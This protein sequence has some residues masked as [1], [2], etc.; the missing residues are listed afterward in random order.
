MSSVECAKLDALD[1]GDIDYNTDGINTQVTYTCNTGYTLDGYTDIICL[2]NGSWQYN[3]SRC[4]KCSNLSSPGNGNYSLYTV[5]S[6]TVTKAAYTC[7]KGYTLMGY[8]E[9]TCQQNGEW[10]RDSPICVKC[11]DR[12]P[13]SSGNF[14]LTTN[15]LQT[16]G[17]Y[18]CNE[19]YILNGTSNVAC[20]ITGDWSY[21]QPT[22]ECV[23][24]EAPQNGSITV[25]QPS[26][27]YACDT[28]Y[29]L[30][31]NSTGMCNTDGTGWSSDT[32]SCVEC[33]SV[34]MVSN[35]NITY[36]SNGVNTYI[37]ILCEEGTTISGNT[38]I[39]CTENGTWNSPLPECVTC[40]SLQEVTVSSGSVT[41]VTNGTVTTANYS[42]PTGYRVKGSQ[43]IQCLSDGTWSDLPSECVCDEPE[44]TEGSGYV[45]SDNGL[46]ITFTCDKGY[47]IN[48][49]VTAECNTD[50][51]GWNMEY[52]N[53][54]KCDNV[55]VPQNGSVSLVSNGTHTTVEFY[56]G[57]GHTLS[58]F[59]V[60]ECQA[61]G[62]WSSTVTTQSCV[63]CESLP[64]VSVVNG[65]VFLSTNGT[66][67][68]AAY[69]CPDGYKV[70]GEDTLTCNNT[71]QW[72]STPSDCV[73]ETPSLLIG[74]NITVVD[75]GYGVIFTCDKGYTM[76]GYQEITCA[77]DGTGWSSS[78]PLCLEC[79]EI[80]T[81]DGGN[82]T[83]VTNGT[84]SAAIYKC[85]V[86]TTLD[87]NT[88]AECQL[89][90][91]WNITAP[92]CVSCP[93]LPNITIETGYVNISTDGM[94]TTAY[95][96]CPPGYIVT[97]EENIT[98]NADG[99]WSSE[100]SDCVCE[101]PLIPQHG[102]YS[103]SINRLSIQYRCDRG[104]IMIG[105][106]TAICNIDGTG[107][108]E[109]SPTCLKCEDLSPPL[110]G[111][112]S[113]ITNGTHSEAVYTCDVGLTLD[114]D[115]TRM[116]LENTT[117]TGGSSQCVECEGI[118][119]IDSG[120]YNK[121]TNGTT[122]SVEYYC[123]PG[124]FIDGS[125]I[126]TCLSD[127]SWDF[128]LPNCY[129]SPPDVILNGSIIYNKTTALYDC[130]TGYSMNGSSI[131]TCQTDSMGWSGV[132]PQC[133][134]CR[135]VAAPTNGTVIFNSDGI[136]TEAIFTCNVGYTMNGSDF[137]TCSN[138]GTWSNDIPNC[139][140]CSELPDTD[141][142]TL[143]ITSNGTHTIASYTCNIGTTMTGTPSIACRTEDTWSDQEPV[144]EVCPSLPTP[145]NG[146]ITLDTDGITTTANLSCVDGY[147]ANGNTVISCLG[148]TGWSDNL[149]SC[150][151]NQPDI[152]NGTVASNGL[153]A[154]FK[155]NIGYSLHGN[156]QIFCDLDGN[157]WNGS[158]PLCVKCADL[159][160]P[161]DGTI[162]MS[163]NGYNTRA[164]VTCD[165][166]TTLNGSQILFCSN[167]GSWNESNPICVKCEDLTHPQNG[168]F[169]ISSDGTVSTVELSCNSGYQT[170][171]LTTVQCGPDGTWQFNGESSCESVGRTE[172]SLLTIL[173]IVSVV[174]M[175]IITMLSLLLAKFVYFYY[176]NKNRL[177]GKYSTNK[178]HIETMSNGIDDDMLWKSKPSVSVLSSKAPA[179]HE[180]HLLETSCP[181]TPSPAPE[182]FV[183]S[184]PPSGSISPML[185][186]THRSGSSLISFRRNP[187]NLTKN[188][189]ASVNAI[190]IT[191]D[192]SD[193]L[194]TSKTN[195][196]DTNI[197]LNRFDSPP[198]KLAP[199]PNHRQ[200]VGKLNATRSKSPENDR[201]KS[202]QDGHS[203]SRPQQD[204]LS[205]SRRQ[206]NN[207]SGTPLLMNHSILTNDFNDVSSLDSVSIID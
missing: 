28:G 186:E 178:A 12:E 104:Y 22:C 153:V 35:G 41:I 97:R 151:C 51:T 13:P 56:C 183:A 99:T 134:E 79:D 112:I 73:C 21:P 117:W 171:G 200:M 166:G 122:T 62:S 194:P 105:E 135:T 145:N 100:P 115:Y 181:F 83:I 150:L 75:E 110:R 189:L 68:S 48:G 18:T 159:L 60:P 179:S 121:T 80:I 108:S 65:S 76:N 160:N 142:G 92:I 1:G 111:N 164:S 91:T 192:I 29:T 31:G 52:P 109:E 149:P 50:G 158:F 23:A 199:L 32:P 176:K 168:E 155:C 163:T 156:S 188:S 162:Q 120:T 5:D 63:S 49:G 137:S 161:T 19:G 82:V 61:D 165:P 118:T 127:G 182:S 126:R 89:D 167:D 128:D 205:G 70:N 46:N 170:S 114:G 34:D 54:T 190:S 180:S 94:I 59:S 147:Y 66:H 204:S 174:S 4:I 2:S 144:C 81:P 101:P 152:E 98:C 64:D 9:L 157:G 74:G 14:T 44:L 102:N 16:R 187:T 27:T 123:S 42:C 6:S 43:T 196:V 69:S 154:I 39:T 7:D 86:G 146:N 191:E 93:D 113:L 58:D 138:G 17:L 67:T 197:A 90:G 57:T 124:Y 45:I 203:I 84:V 96:N 10:N 198:N 193:D 53:C 129:C 119:D 173:I 107:W 184:P 88:S 87:G 30:L 85:N 47:T 8:S 72:N 169:I 185:V 175:A 172:N 103:L 25:N 78:Y 11:E 15:G 132:S 95:Y 77:T 116:C 139:V 38:I 148:V 143:N 106:H 20:T 207:R 125:A 33:E 26:I 37:T 55:S 3:Q 136:V 202:Q 24:P 133:V 140:H 206:I 177:S 131:R 40:S 36:G 195:G 130:H 201:T 141:D 71:G